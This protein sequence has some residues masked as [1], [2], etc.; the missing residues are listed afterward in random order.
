MNRAARPESGLGFLVH[1]SGQKTVVPWSSSSEAP[2]ELPFR[3]FSSVTTQTLR[4]LAST[5]ISGLV[6]TLPGVGRFLV[7]FH[8]GW[9]GSAE[10]EYAVLLHSLGTREHYPEIR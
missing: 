5:V 9:Q 4:R 6:R 8:D 2:S 1:H 3:S 7:L 10:D